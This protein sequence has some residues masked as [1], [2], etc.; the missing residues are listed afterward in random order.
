[1]SDLSERFDERWVPVTEAGCWIWIGGIASGLQPPYGCM[2]VGDKSVLAHR[3]SWV[4]HRGE[5]PDGLCVLHKCDA[6][7]CVNPAHLFLGSRG[8]NNTDRKR[9]GR[10]GDTRGEKHPASILTEEQVLEIRADTRLQRE[11][12]QSFG[13]AQGQ[14]SM[15]KSHNSWGHVDA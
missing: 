8:D 7:P 1:M 6:P 15:I 2:R 14:I 3:I 10:N 11:I 12:A 9:K 4:L 13:I 5:I